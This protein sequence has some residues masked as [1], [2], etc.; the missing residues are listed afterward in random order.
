MGR[1]AQEAGQVKPTIDETIK[2]LEARAGALREAKAELPDIE[3]SGAFLVSNTL[4]VDECD[5]Y[6]FEITDFGN[7]SIVSLFLGKSFKADGSDV[8]VWRSESTDLDLVMVRFFASLKG[9][10]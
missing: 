5:Q 7:D 8:V 4:R 3:R 1:N 6:R 10:S 2:D 9:G